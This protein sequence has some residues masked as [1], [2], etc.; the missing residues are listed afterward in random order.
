MSIIEKAESGANSEPS[1][2][3]WRKVECSVKE[4]PCL[5]GF[6]ALFIV[7]SYTATASG[8]IG[9]AVLVVVVEATEYEF[10]IVPI[11]M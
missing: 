7:L 2:Y 9:F 4:K 1:N 6:A 8:L 5:I 3:V 10:D 11:E